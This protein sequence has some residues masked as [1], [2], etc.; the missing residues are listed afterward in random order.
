M[1][2]SAVDGSDAVDTFVQARSDISGKDTVLS[3][4]VQAFEER[5]G[6]GRGRSGLVE[7][8]KLLNDDVR[9]TLDVAVRCVY[10]L[11]SSE[12]R[13]RSIGEEA[14]IEVLDS[15]LYSKVFVCLDLT[16][17]LGEHEFRRGHIRGSSNDTHGRRVAGAG[18]DL[19]TVGDREVGGRTEV[20]EVVAGR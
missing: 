10:L 4:I 9:V 8:V 15:E 11:R 14:G 16:T 19:L 7:G 18:L 2:S 13:L 17:V 20:D 1:V 6:T 3:S 12:V 5:E